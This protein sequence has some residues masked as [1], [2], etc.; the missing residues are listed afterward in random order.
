MTDLSASPS[1]VIA[2]NYSVKSTVA[3][4]ST[5][6][7]VRFYG[8]KSDCVGYGTASQRENNIFR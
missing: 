6:T 5:G 3:D 2:K 4:V 7:V 1:Y 8:R